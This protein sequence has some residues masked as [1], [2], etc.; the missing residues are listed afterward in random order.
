MTE[1]SSCSPHLEDSDEALYRLV[2]LLT[3][4]SI[5]V[6][7]NPEYDPRVLDY[8]SISKETLKKRAN[9]RITVRSNVSGIVSELGSANSIVKCML[10]RNEIQYLPSNHGLGHTVRRRYQ[11]DRSTPI[12]QHVTSDARVLYVN[13]PASTPHSHS[14]QNAD[15]YYWEIRAQFRLIDRQKNKTWVF[16]ALAPKATPID[17]EKETDPD[18]RRTNR[19]LWADQETH[20]STGATG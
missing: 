11:P 7:N 6:E 13:T 9:T 8:G 10:V 14:F 15:Q 4:V 20:A 1:R 17:M 18:F 12:L 16:P 5:Q 19:P 3:G 2:G